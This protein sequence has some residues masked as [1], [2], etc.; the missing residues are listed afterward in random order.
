MRLEISPSTGDEVQNLLE[1][2]YDTPPGLVE[3][4]HA[5]VN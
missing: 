2:A 4:A 3:R 1:E 5:L